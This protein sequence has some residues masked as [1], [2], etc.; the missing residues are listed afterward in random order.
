[1]VGG[2]IATALGCATFGDVPD[3]ALRASGGE[4]TIASLPSGSFEGVRFGTAAIPPDAT[5]VDATVSI[6]RAGGTPK[7]PATS[8]KSKSGRFRVPVLN[9]LLL[10][11]SCW[12]SSRP[13]VEA[14]DSVLLNLA[15]GALF[16][17]A[18]DVRASLNF[19]DSVR[20]IMS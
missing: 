18:A 6:P 10:S 13:A 9:V 11:T 5:G 8:S 4:V 20:D 7:P 19:W 17:K 1:M 14:S 2:T 12:A 16:I 3:V 15:L